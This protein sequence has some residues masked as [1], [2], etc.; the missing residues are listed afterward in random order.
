MGQEGVQVKTPGRRTLRRVIV[1][2][3]PWVAGELDSGAQ[4]LPYRP[5]SGLAE[6]VQLR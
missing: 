2:L 3:I 1:L 4:L 6:E 5:R